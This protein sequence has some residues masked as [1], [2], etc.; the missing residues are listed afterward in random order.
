MTASNANNLSFTL[1]NRSILLVV[2]RQPF[3]DWSD[4][5]TPD[6]PKTTMD[7][8][9]DHNSYLLKD[10]VHIDEPEE[11][12]KD[13]WAR[14]FINELHSYTDGPTTYP[15]LS[16]E[17]FVEWFDLHLSNFAHDLIDAPVYHQYF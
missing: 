13:Y 2:P 11:E 7:E 3:Y 16:W 8:A 17:L 10:G 12:L 14:I 1:Y 9:Q 6:F 15:E 5:L 4:A